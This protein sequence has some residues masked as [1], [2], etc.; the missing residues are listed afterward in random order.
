MES[1]EFFKL[2]E[3]CFFKS[4][5]QVFSFLVV[6]TLIV[7]TVYIFIKLFKRLFSLLSAKHRKARKRERDI[8]NENIIRESQTSEEDISVQSK[9]KVP[10]G[11]LKSFS[12]MEAEKEK[13][14]E[15]KFR[16]NGS[17]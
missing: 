10:K 4:F 12:S 11:V 8:E 13:S 9:T 7:F 15:D 5:M 3:E 2:L 17:W 14:L 1:T 6:V 16:N